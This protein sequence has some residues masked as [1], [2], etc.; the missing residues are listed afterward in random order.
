MFSQVSGWEISGTT[1]RLL[2]AS[3]KTVAAFNSP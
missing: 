2:D 1:L 3:G